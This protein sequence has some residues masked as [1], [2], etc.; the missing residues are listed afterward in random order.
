MLGEEWLKQESFPGESE[1]QGCK[2]LLN[3]CQEILTLK[4]LVIVILDKAAS[5]YL[6]W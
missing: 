6:I 2:L 4:E 3:D 5:R 1:R